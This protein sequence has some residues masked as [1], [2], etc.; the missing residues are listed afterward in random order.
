MEYVEAVRNCNFALR[1][2]KRFDRLSNDENLDEE[3]RKELKEE[4]HKWWEEATKI[5]RDISQEIG[6]SQFQNIQRAI[7]KGEI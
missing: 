3:T 4:A 6:F 2:V 7:I 5:R 1:Y